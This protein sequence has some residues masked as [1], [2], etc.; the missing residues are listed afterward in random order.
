MGGSPPLTGTAASSGPRVLGAPA[1]EILARVLWHIGEPQTL[2]FLR[3]RRA[4]RFASF[5]FIALS[6]AFIRHFPEDQSAIELELEV[7]T[8]CYAQI[9]VASARWR[10]FL[11]LRRGAARR[12]AR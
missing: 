10:I 9:C 5:G 7:L 1:A 12:G 8:E 2:N 11:R 6:L 3:L 4:I